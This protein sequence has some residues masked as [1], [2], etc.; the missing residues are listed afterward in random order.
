MSINSRGGTKRTNAGLGNTS[1]TLA[2]AGHDYCDNF[3]DE[4]PPLPVTPTKSP[5]QKKKATDIDISPALLAQF[6]T[7][8]TLINNRADSI[9]SRIMML[10]EK[11]QRATADLEAVTTRVTA[12]EQNLTKVEQPVTHILRRMDEMETHM[13]RNNLRLDGVPESQRDEDIRKKVIS[14]CQEVIPALRD[15]LE[16][17]IDAAHRLGRRP[18]NTEGSRPRTI[19][20]HFAS[21]ETKEAVWKA[22]KASS[23]L[24]HNGLR[25]KEDLSKGDRERRM[26]L[27]PLVKK[28]R[29]ASK[30]AY[31]VGGRA[32]IVGGGEVVLEDER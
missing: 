12:L 15:Q 16:R 28:A 2:A 11:V 22:A 4:F 9:E 6:E 19:I 31:F 14:V 20:L 8:K 21:R 17:D 10:E 24:Q 29:E 5:A 32:F 23:Y 30:T 25:F 3:E 18:G 13:R 1:K 27:W 26:K 7:L